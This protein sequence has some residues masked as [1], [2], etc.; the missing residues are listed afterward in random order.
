MSMEKLAEQARSILEHPGS[1]TLWVEGQ[2][3]PVLDEH[4]QAVHDW[5]GTPEF[6]CISGSPLVDAAHQHARAV[7]QVTADPA[8]SD[9]LILRGKLRWVNSERCYC[10]GE[11][12]EC[13]ILMP[14]GITLELADQHIPISRAAF[15]DP[16]LQLNPGFLERNRQHINRS[17]DEE[18]RVSVSRHSNTPYED[19][20]AAQIVDLAVDHVEVD[21]VTLTGA[22]RETIYFKRTARTTSELTDQLRLALRVLI[23]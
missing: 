20:L 13:L 5:H 11:T 7:L 21:W 8:G 1:M 15:S 22:Q 19:V 16:A 23:C 2:E 6:R 10:C 18:L 3:Q 17:H 14:E 9:T 4:L 12:R